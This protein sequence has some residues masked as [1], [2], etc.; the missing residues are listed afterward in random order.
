MEVQIRIKNRAKPDRILKE[1]PD[2]V[3][4]DD[5]EGEEIYFAGKII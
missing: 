5:S 4:D 1:Y 2:S 3:L